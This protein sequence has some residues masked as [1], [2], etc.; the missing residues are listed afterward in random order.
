MLTMRTFIFVLP[1]RPPGIPKRGW[2]ISGGLEAWRTF[3]DVLSEAL[4]LDGEGE[5]VKRP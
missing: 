2:G 5:A 1:K 3:R 4:R